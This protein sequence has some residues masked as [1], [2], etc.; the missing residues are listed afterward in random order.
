[1]R[2]EDVQA[3]KAYATVQGHKVKVIDN[4]PGWTIVDGAYVKDDTKATRFVQGTT[5][6]Y[7]SNNHI[8]I[9]AQDG[10]PTVIEPRHLSMLWSEYEAQRKSAVAARKDATSNAKAL[11]VRAK[12]AGLG[13]I[14]T[15][16]DRQRVTLSFDDFDTLL[17]AVKA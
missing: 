17:R 15:D 2:R 1:M 8:R 5:I 16:P 6:S 9:T 14:A 12:T 3:G 11:T 7:A 13:A 10:T 4:D